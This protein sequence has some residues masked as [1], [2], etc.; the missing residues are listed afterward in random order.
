[1]AGDKVKVYVE[2]ADVKDGFH[3]MTCY[4]PSYEI[5]SV[6]GF[7]KAEQDKYME[8]IRSTAHLIMEFSKDGGFENASGF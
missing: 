7:S 8:I 2:K 1:V 3:D 6:H 5:T 4:L